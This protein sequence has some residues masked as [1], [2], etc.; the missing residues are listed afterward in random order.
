MAAANTVLNAVGAFVGGLF[1][2]GF[3]IVAFKFGKRVVERESRRPRPDEQPKLPKEWPVHE[4]REVREPDE[5]PL[6][7]DESERL[8]PYQLHPARTKRSKDQ[9]PKKWTP[10]ASGSFGS[11]GLGRI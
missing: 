10:G 3:L 11:G 9:H 2:A 7:H 8:M 6:A 1:I 4:E 5:M